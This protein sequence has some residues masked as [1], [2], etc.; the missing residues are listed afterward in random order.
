MKRKLFLLGMISILLAVQ[1]AALVEIE[2]QL[3]TYFLEGTSI[4]GVTN[5]A[6]QICDTMNYNG[7]NDWF[8]PSVE[9]LD[10]MYNNLKA[11]DLGDFRNDASYWASSHDP[12]YDVEQAEKLNNSVQ[13][14]QNLFV[15]PARAF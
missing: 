1:E 7:F 5:N 11:K 15:R 3:E 4:N 2:F 8:L 14:F 6:V 10:L 12:Q 9:E 13:S